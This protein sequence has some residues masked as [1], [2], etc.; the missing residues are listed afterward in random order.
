MIKREGACSSRMSPRIALAHAARGT[1]AVGLMIA[2]VAA[3][4]VRLAMIAATGV[5]TYGA[6]PDSW[7]VLF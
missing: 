5:S 7:S 2:G 3:T 6:S 1:V 4:A